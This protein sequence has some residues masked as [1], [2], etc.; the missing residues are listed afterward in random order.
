MQVT[1]VLLSTWS[2]ISLVKTNGLIC[3]AVT[4]QQTKETNTGGEG[5]KELISSFLET[6]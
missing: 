1:A 2:N 5:P 6:E 4:T 3:L